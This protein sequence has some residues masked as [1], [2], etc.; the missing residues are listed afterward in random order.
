MNEFI[1]VW[2][3]K[4]KKINKRRHF[5]ISRS[6]RTNLIAMPEVTI[7]AKWSHRDNRVG[8]KQGKTDDV[9]NR[10]WK[11]HTGD[12]NWPTAVTNAPHPPSRPNWSQQLRP[13]SRL[14]PFSAPFLQS[15]AAH[16]FLLCVFLHLSLSCVIWKSSQLQHV[17]NQNIRQVLQQQNLPNNMQQA[18]KVGVN[19]TLS[20]LATRS[21]TVF[22]DCNWNAA[23]LEVSGFP[24]TKFQLLT[25]I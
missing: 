11:L 22:I 24:E 5:N 7:K 19:Q 21:Q 6:W 13:L 1:H 10:L 14:C 2:N 16:K 17:G 20:Q 12:W 25:C 3:R 8:R 9:N 4:V 18:S 23:I 15:S